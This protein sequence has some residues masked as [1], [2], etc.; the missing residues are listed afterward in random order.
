MKKKL[1][2]RLS[3]DNTNKTNKAKMRSSKRKSLYP[4][5][6]VGLDDDL[7]GD[8]RRRRLTRAL[9][10]RETFFPRL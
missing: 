5:K 4:I 6:E 7:T 1:V 3:K 8:G 9:N 2:K 10:K